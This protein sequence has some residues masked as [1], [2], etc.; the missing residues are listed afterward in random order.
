MT[1][2]DLN[3][4]WE[5][6]PYRKGRTRIDAESIVASGFSES[7]ASPRPG[8]GQTGNTNPSP[9]KSEFTREGRLGKDV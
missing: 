4:T 1:R 2:M 8:R 9:H 6:S 3:V 5:D 7:S